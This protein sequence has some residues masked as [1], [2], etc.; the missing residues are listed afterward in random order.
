MKSVSGWVELENSS[1]VSPTVSTKRVKRKAAVI[2]RGKPIASALADRRASA[3]RLLDGGYAEAGK[4]AELG[5][6]HHRADDQDR[7][8]EQHPDRS[9]QAGEDHEGEEV[10]RHL[11]VLGGARLD[12]LPDDGISRHSLG[13]LDRAIRGGGDLRIDRLHRDRS[14]RIDVELAQVAD[15]HAGIL[16]GDVAEDHVALG[17][18]GG[19]GE[20]D[21]VAD[22]RGRVEQ[23]E[24]VPGV[25]ARHHDPQVDHREVA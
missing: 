9:D 18:L 15:H 10:E 12:L 17:L 1:G 4:R 16:A 3:G 14:L 11:D 7:R 21:Q 5:A 13:S 8:V 19:A 22:R 2:P 6:H 25:V 24:H 23:V 20:I